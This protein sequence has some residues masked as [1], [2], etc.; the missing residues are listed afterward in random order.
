MNRIFAIG[1]ALML[2]TSAMSAE[3]DQKDVAVYG[4]NI[5][6][7][8]AGSGP[9]I[10]LLHGL[11]GGLNEW[12]PVIGPLS[13]SHRVIV[14]DFIGF[15][16]SDKPDVSYHNALLAQFLAGFIDAT[17]PEVV[18]FDYRLKAHRKHNLL[19]EL[20][21]FGIGKV[22][23]PAMAKR[24]GIEQVSTAH[25]LSVKQELYRGLGQLASSLRGG[26]NN[27]WLMLHMRKDVVEHNIDDPVRRQEAA[28]CHFGL[29]PAK[30]KA[31]SPRGSRRAHVMGS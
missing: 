1:A 9:P 4:Q 31:P 5:H 8:E 19:W 29:S 13:E 22:R 26:K 12:E 15:H 30:Q 6:Y 11:W 16:G 14:M 28:L 3:L 24:G 23:A 25:G 7:A 27:P 2:S 18:G 21:F 20:S 17:N 10:I